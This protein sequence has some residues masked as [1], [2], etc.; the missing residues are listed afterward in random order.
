MFQVFIK[1]VNSFIDSLIAY[2]VLGIFLVSIGLFV[3]VFPQNVLDYAYADLTIFFSICP[4]TFMFLIPALSMKT[5][6]EEYKTG[7]IE[8]LLTHPLKLSSIVLGKYFANLSL[9]IIGLLPTLL[10]CFCIYHLGSPKGNLD[11]L[12]IVSAY[13]GLILLAST[14]TA[15]GCFCSILSLN[16]V[17]AFVLSVFISYLFYDGLT[18]FSRINIWSKWAYF[19][20]LLG[21]DYHY[22]ALNKGVLASKH[23]IYLCSLDAIFLYFTYQ[24]LSKTA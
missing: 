9:V 21:I 12:A 17:S 5:F 20:G 19:I 23:I 24:R 11:I 13:I 6:A 16:Q 22:E 7:T 4:Y 14:F 8:L 18:L 2:I 1:E 10:Y 3:W 15:I